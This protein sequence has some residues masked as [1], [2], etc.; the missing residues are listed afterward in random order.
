MLSFN[1]YYIFNRPGLGITVSKPGTRECYSLL[2]GRVDDLGAWFFM[3]AG[4]RSDQ[5]WSGATVNG[6]PRNMRP[7]PPTPGTQEREPDSVRPG[8]RTREPA[9]MTQEERTREPASMSP[10]ERTSQYDTRRE[11]QPTWNKKREPASLRPA[12]LS[13]LGAGPA[14][15]RQQD[16]GRVFS[17]AKRAPKS[18]IQLRSSL[19]VYCRLL[20]RQ[21]PW[22]IQ[23]IHMDKRGFTMHAHSCKIYHARTHTP[24]PF[25]SFWVRSLVMVSF[26]PASELVKN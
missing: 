18:R 3:L 22:L 9:T 24:K 26:W 23:K 20:K 17:F 14:T 13:H 16:G 10:G 2:S 19:F 12:R 25:C 5:H 1:P 21:Q 15:K 11:N 7:Q 8:E 6:P 4:W